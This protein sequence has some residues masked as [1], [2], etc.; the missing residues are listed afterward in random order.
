[1]IQRQISRAIAITL[2]SLINLAALAPIAQS[3]EKQA[4][5]PPPELNQL[6]YFQGTWRC[7]GKPIDPS[8]SLPP[9]E[10]SWNVKRDLDNFWYIGQAEQKRS[11][12]N[13]N[14]IKSREF[15]GYDAASKN[16]IRLIV[17][18]GGDLLNFRSP[19]WQARTLIWEGTLVT[20][21]QKIPL[22][23]TITQKNENEFSATYYDFSQAEG[24]WKPQSEEI[25]KK[26]R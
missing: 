15:L 12:V 22:R 5:Q 3:Q 26:L 11:P 21:G 23:E 18:S 10:L 9:I 17:A 2:L 1:M 8:S 7:D 25:C 24:Q 4:S 19:G 16:F 20:R 13:P 14:P 6:Q